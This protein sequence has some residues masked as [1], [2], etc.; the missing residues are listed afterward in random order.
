MAVSPFA[1]VLVIGLGTYVIRLSFIGIVGARP[2]PEWAAAPLRYVAPA[3]LAALI[4]PAVM[5]NGGAL[6]LSPVS[7]PRFLAAVLAGLA[8]W[9]LGNVIWAVIVGMGSLWLLQWLL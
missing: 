2:V 5:L 9:R 8:V 6:D 1:V 3:V 7:N 4:A